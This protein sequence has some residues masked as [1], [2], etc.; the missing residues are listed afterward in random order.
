MDF[1]KKVVGVC[2]YNMH[3]KVR[4]PVV[5]GC[6]VVSGEKEWRKRKSNIFLEFYRNMEHEGRNK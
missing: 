2:D 5:E 4:V 6:E 3:Y 1:E